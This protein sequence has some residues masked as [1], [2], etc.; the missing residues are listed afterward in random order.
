SVGPAIGGAIVAAA[1]AAAA[2]AVNSLSYIALILVLLRWRP[3]A[4]PQLLPRETLGIAIAAGVRYVAL[5]PAIRTVLI[6]SAIFGLGASAIMALLPLVAR[7]Q[8][9]GGPLTYGLLLGAFG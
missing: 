7:D 8:I 1:G 4:D 2:F 9:A 3:Q 5:S 6:R